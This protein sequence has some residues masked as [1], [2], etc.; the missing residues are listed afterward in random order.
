MNL[1]IY[2]GSIYKKGRIQENKDRC[3][4]QYIKKKDVN[5][6]YEY[7]N[8]IIKQEYPLNETSILNISNKINEIKILI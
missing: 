1:K 3:R 2:N 7:N 6:L 4:I 5:N 8:I